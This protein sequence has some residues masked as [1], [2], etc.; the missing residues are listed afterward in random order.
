MMRGKPYKVRVRR[1]VE[2]WVDVSAV[3]GA[4]AEA[5]ARNLPGVIFVFSPSAVLANRLASASVAIGV[6]D[7]IEER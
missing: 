2:D 1:S 3:D 7:E 5:L 6:E 4:Q